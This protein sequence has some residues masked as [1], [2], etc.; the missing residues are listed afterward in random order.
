LILGLAV[1][2]VAQAVWIYAL[3]LGSISGLSAPDEIN[4]PPMDWRNIGW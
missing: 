2:A 1:A 4:K 3:M